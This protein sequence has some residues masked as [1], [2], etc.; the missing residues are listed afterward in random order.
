MWQTL[1]SGSRESCSLDRGVTTTEPPAFLAPRLPPPPFCEDLLTFRMA[2]NR[3]DLL[4]LFSLLS[5]TDLLFNKSRSSPVSTT[6][7]YS[8]LTCF[9]LQAT[10][11]RLAA[12]PFFANTSTPVQGWSSLCVGTTKSCLDP[13]PSD[14]DFK[15]D[16]RHFGSSILCSPPPPPAP[17]PGCDFHP[18]NDG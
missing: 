11:I 8:F 9:L 4:P 10:C 18:G 16:R 14:W 1:P 13:P 7:Q 5:G 15:Y 6:T 2:D 17:F 3:N 12:L